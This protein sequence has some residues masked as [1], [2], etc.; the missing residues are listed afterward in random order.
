MHCIFSTEGVHKCEG[1]H[2]PP[3]I[4]KGLSFVYLEIK[5]QCVFFQFHSPLKYNCIHKAC[6]TGTIN[7]K[8]DKNQVYN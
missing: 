4:L 6:Y 1:A 8:Q 3:S 2:A 7:I 5:E